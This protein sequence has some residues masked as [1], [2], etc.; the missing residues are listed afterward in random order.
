MSRK[1]RLKNV[2][3]QFLGQSVSINLLDDG[4]WTKIWTKCLDCH[5]AH[6]YL[7]KFI[8]DVATLGFISQSKS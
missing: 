3:E 6:V 1:T 8:A 5:D 2:S 7:D 4:I